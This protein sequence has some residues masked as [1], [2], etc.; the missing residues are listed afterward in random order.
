M[1]PL[2]QLPDT[3]EQYDT[4]LRARGTTQYKAGYLRYSIVDGWQQI[5]KD[6]AY[7]RAAVK[8]AE[9]AT[10]PEERAWLEA[11]RRLR[12]KLTLRDIGIGSHYVGDLA[13]PACV[14]PLQRLGRPFKSLLVHDK[15]NP[16]LLRRGVL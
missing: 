4:L 12:E 6:F 1:L 8:G 16:R 7:W 15:E 11:D 14:G 3:R 10:T 13:A 2:A 5:R 9:T